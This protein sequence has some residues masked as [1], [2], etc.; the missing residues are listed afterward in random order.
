M[1][2]TQVL[3]QTW[4]LEGSGLIGLYRLD[5][6]RCILLDSGEQFEREEL[7]D[8]LD[9]AG[10]T[11]VGVLTSHI[12]TDH[13]INNGWLSRRYGC[14]AAVPAG[15]AH[16]CRSAL[17]LKSYLSCYSPGTLARERGEMVCR[18]DHLIP[19]DADR[20]S[21]CGAEFRIVHTPGHSLDHLSII[22][23]DNV[24]YTGDAVFSGKLLT[25]KLPYGLCLSMMMDSAQSLKG[26]DCPAYIVPHRGVCREIGPLADATCELIRRRGEEILALVDHPMTW[27]EIWRAAIQHFSLYSSHPLHAALLSRN[28]CSYLDYLTDTGALTLTAQ[29]G[30][31]LYQR[32]RS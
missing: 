14:Q 26:L 19:L 21:F 7:A 23:P 5:D 4:V 15:E 30:L 24:C 2:L 8:A 29:R 10:L 16:L 17:A 9:A 11:P 13:S 3:G 32:T 18:P 31:V 25:A 12:H 20:F 27:E 28:F 6:R 22:T 1:K